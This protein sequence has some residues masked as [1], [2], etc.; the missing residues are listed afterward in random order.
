MTGSNLRSDRERDEAGAP[1]FLI[2]PRLGDA[3]DDAS[4]PK[5][6]SLLAIAGSLLAEISL[7]ETRVRLYDLAPAAGGAAWHCAAGQRPPGSPRFREHVVATDGNRRLTGACAGRRTGMV[8][9][10]AAIPDRRGQLLVAQRAGG[11]AG[12]CVLPRG[13]A[14]SGRADVRPRFRRRRTRARLRALSSAG[15]GIFL[16]GMRR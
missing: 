12:I 1:L 4:S 13:D 6:K 15:A 2:D 11:P 10:A 7:H 5:Q 16:C 9:M 8:R 3:E 14:P